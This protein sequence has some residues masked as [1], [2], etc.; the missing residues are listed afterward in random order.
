MPEDREVDL[1]AKI[2]LDGALLCV[3][4]C[5]TLKTMNMYQGFA[6]SVG[7]I[8]HSTSKVM[9]L[10]TGLTISLQLTLNLA[11]NVVEC[12]PIFL[13]WAHVSCIALAVVAVGV[14]VSGPRKSSLS[15]SVEVKMLVSYHPLQAWYGPMITM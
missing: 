2:M 3:R 13:W 8:S 10:N 11:E 9:Q 4:W 6:K 15:K 1:E 7:C 5:I 14:N 12:K